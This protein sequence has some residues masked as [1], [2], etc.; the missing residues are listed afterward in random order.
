MTLWAA[1]PLSN[2]HDS[3]LS[4][5]TKG[6][7]LTRVHCLQLHV[8]LWN[9]IQHKQIWGLL[10][11]SRPAASWAPA[12]NNPLCIAATLPLCPAGAMH[13]PRVLWSATQLLEG[14]LLLATAQP[15]SIHLNCAATVPYNAHLRGSLAQRLPGI[16]RG[17]QAPW[18]GRLSTNWLQCHLLVSPPCSQVRLFTGK[19]T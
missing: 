1:S 3:L 17:H 10:S 15:T 5:K 4:E 11:S 8:S 18:L 6:S 16:K 7:G 2:D 9:Q 19:H 14:V 13:G 12:E